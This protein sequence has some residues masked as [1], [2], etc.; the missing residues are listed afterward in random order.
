M[1]RNIS[2]GIDIG[3]ST[4]RVVVGE[5]LKG[6]KNPKIIGVGESE[7]KG[8][9]RGYII[10]AADAISSLK[11]AVAMAEKSS[12]IRIRRAFISIGSTTLRSEVGNGS[13][14][15]SKADSEVTKLDISKALDE[16]ETNLAMGNK[17]ILHAFPLSF[18]LDGKEVLGRP[19]GMHG[20]KL[21][22]KALFITCSTK[23]WEDLIEVITNA[24][25]EPID[26]V[27]GILASSNIALSGRH[28]MVGSALIDIGAETVSLGVF[29]NELLIYLYTF[30]IGSEDITNDIALGLKIPLEKA[31]SLKLGNSIEEYPKKKLDEIIEARLTDIFE[32]VENYLKKIKRSELLPAGVVFVG[33]GSNTA[34]IEDLSKNILKLPSKI[35]STDIFGTAKTKLRDPSWYSALGLVVGSKDNEG[36]VEGS[37]SNLIKDLK[38]SLKSMVKQLMP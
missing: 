18:K 21:E 24:G 16:C 23:H 37:F 6:E 14:I 7:T 28:K 11:S 34:N 31:E 20:N 35:A 8:M 10:H 15:I 17:K 19:E 1:I 32:G 13:T 38:H 27:A 5:F 36:Y 30:S 4:T 2:V 12:G 3:T 29:E 22:I 9:R 33:G 26:V 25:V